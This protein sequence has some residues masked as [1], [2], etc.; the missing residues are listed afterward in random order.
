MELNYKMKNTF[1]MRGFLQ[2][3][4][5]PMFSGKTSHLIHSIHKFL[6]VNDARGTP[7]KGL[8][9]NSSMDK[10][11]VKSTCDNL[12][13]HSTFSKKMRED[14]LCLKV[15]ELGALEE[16]VIDEIDFIAVDEAQ[17]F[18]DIEI[19]KNWLKKG[20]YIHLC[21]LIA[22]T[23]K[24]PF[25]NLLKLFPLADDVEQLKA[26]CIFCDCHSMNAPFTDIYSGDSPKEDIYP[27]GYET[28]IP[29]CGK[30]YNEK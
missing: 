17:F 24:K 8:I 20:K 29:V 9:I 30:H 14:I 28:Y 7:K 3:T 1:K 4:F 5:G 23:N 26:Y 22:D 2:I 19:V 27:G 18:T 25:G 10:R 16:E 12:T 15:M 13:T 11:I 6:D 21:G